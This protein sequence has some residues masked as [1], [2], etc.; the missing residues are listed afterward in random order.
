MKRRISLVL[1]TLL[2]SLGLMLPAAPAFAQIDIFKN[3]CNTQNAA[4]QGGA[5]PPRAG[6]QGS[7]VCSTNGSDPFS[8][9]NG[10]LLKVANI[11]SYLAGISAVILVIVGGL[12]YVLS[13]GDSSKISDA[14]TTIIYALVGLVIV[15]AA[16]TIV[17]FF[18]N[19]I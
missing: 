6:T 9:P 1:A 2:L 15:V 12:M 10:V 4:G 16:R 7:T 13:N 14:K 17:I 19:R 11:I 8:G 5:G 18:I 3:A